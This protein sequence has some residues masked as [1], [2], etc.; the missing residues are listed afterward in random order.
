[1]DN[2]TITLIGSILTALGGIVV[3]FGWASDAVVAQAIGLILSTVSG[4]GA[5]WAAHRKDREL[6]ATKATI[7]AIS[8]RFTANG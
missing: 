5:I 6:A 2:K 4:A 8:G 1:M 3:G 7:S